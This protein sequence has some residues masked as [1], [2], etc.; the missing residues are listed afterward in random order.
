MNSERAYPVRPVI[1]MTIEHE[2]QFLHELRVPR[3]RGVLLVL[4]N[5][6]EA[7]NIIQGE[8][9]LAVVTP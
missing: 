4:G 7:A 5:V 1:T 3:L 8:S 2:A 9:P 6:F